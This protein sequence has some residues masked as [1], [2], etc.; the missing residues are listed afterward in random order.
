MLKKPAWRQLREFLILRLALRKEA[1]EADLLLLSPS[2]R[3]LLFMKTY[4]ELTE[5][6]ANY[7][8][9]SYLG[10]SEVSLSRIRSRLGVQNTYKKS[11]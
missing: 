10:I 6:L 7:H 11:D 3:Y 2:E 5:I 8:I 4:P 1:R 9:A